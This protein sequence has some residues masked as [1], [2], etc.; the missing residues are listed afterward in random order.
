M[1]LSTS[2]PTLA[3]APSAK[4]FSIQVGDDVVVGSGS[5]S[6]LVALDSDFYDSALARVHSTL[7]HSSTR[8]GFWLVHGLSMMFPIGVASLP[9]CADYRSPISYVDVATYEVGIGGQPV[10]SRL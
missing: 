8:V 5:F 4:A 3:S 2:G 9:H 6:P 1:T 7:P 10:H